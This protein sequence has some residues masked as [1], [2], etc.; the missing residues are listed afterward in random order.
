MWS[1]TLPAALRQLPAESQLPAASNA[2]SSHVGC[3]GGYSTLK[4]NRNDVEKQARFNRITFLF[5]G[6]IVPH[7]GWIAI[8]RTLRV[9]TQMADD[10]SA[11]MGCDW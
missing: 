9:R 3:Y 1:A 2:A 7:S 4:R 10:E 5:H 11:M 6:R 8:Q